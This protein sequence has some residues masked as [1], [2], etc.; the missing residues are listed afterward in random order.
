MRPCWL[1]LSDPRGRRVTRTRK[2][3]GRTE[4]YAEL[5]RLHQV[6]PAERLSAEQDFWRCRCSWSRSPLMLCRQ[7]TPRSGRRRVHSRGEEDLS[8]QAPGWAGSPAGAAQGTNDSSRI[9][10]NPRQRAWSARREA[11]RAASPSGVTLNRRSGAVRVT[12]RGRRFFPLEVALLL[13]AIEGGVESAT[14]DLSASGLLRSQRVPTKSERCFS[15][16]EN[17]EENQLFEF[18]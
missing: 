3:R 17:G 15:T 7:Q 16:L 9:S 1:A 2:K 12:V 6:P 14:R 8:R 11:R 18:T 4:T 10:S 5:Q 13:E